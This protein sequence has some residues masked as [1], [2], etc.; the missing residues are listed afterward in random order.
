M[1]MHISDKHKLKSTHLFPQNTVLPH[2]P[3]SI[4]CKH[5]KHPIWGARYSLSLMT[6]EY[7]TNKAPG[8]T[9]VCIVQKFR[10]CR[11]HWKGMV[12]KCPTLISKSGQEQHTEVTGESQ[13]Q[14]MTHMY[15]AILY[16]L[17]SKNHKGSVWIMLHY[18][19]GHVWD[20][21]WWITYL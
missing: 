16:H 3:T 15:H 18:Q 6:L 19:R 20:S 9:A 4:K 1:R 7:P 2:V 13:K 5:T 21:Y 11:D 10:G 12:A 8:Q 14:S 17:V